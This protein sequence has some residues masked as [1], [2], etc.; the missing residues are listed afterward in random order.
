MDAHEH[1][2]IDRDPEEGDWYTLNLEY[3]LKN[4]ST[5][6]RYYYLNA[7]VPAMKGIERILST[8]EQVFEGADLQTVKDSVTRITVWQE[9]YDEN[10]MY[11]VS[12]EVPLPEEAIGTLLEAIERD[13]REGTMAQNMVF[14]EKE[15]ASLTFWYD[16]AFDGRYIRSSLTVFEDSAHTVAALEQ[17]LQ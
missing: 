2:L 12:N 16:D 1:A 6:R 14:H 9:I 11:M 7:D 17:Y 13:C 15:F 10:G 3:T 5:L 8:W 4:G